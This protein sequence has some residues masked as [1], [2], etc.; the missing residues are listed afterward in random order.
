MKKLYF[1]IACLLGS[2]SECYE[3]THTEKKIGP[4]K[5]RIELKFNFKPGEYLYKE[6]I[7][8]SVNNPHVKLST[9]E[10]SK[11]ATSFFDEASKKQ[12]EGYKDAVTFTLTTEKEPGAVVNEALV[13]MHFSVNT[14]QEPQEKFVAVQFDKRAEKV[15]IGTNVDPALQ[16]K[17]AVA[18]H[19]PGCEVQEP[20]FLGSFIKK[21][22]NW[23]QTSVSRSKATLTTLFTSTGSWA[24]RF[25]AALILGILLSLTPCI[26]PMIP[27]T[28]GI[29]QA[30]GSPSTFKNFLL[31]L[32]YTLGIS[33]TFALLGFFAAVGSCVFGEMQGSP[34]IIIPLALLL[35]YFGLTMFDWVH[36]YIPRFLMPKTGKV[37]GGSPLSAFIFGAISGTIASPCLS[38][39]LVLILNYV[40]NISAQHFS[41]YLEGF[42][43]LFIF[44]IGSS[45]PLLIIGTFSSSLHVLPK[46]GMWMVEIKKIVGLMLIS[47]AFYHLSHLERLLPWYIFVWVIVVSF[48]AL[49]IYYF[50]SIHAHDRTIMKHYK[51]FMGTALIIVACIM[52]LQGQK[53]L[54]DHLHPH[55]IVSAWF[56]DYDQAKEKALKEGK[57]L[58]IDI[59]ATYCAACASL[60]QRIFAV[61]KIQEVLSAF[62]QLKVESDVH[63]TSYERL[64]SIYGKYIEGYPTYLVVDPK[65]DTVLKKWSVEI[66]D[67]SMAGIVDELEKIKSSH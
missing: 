32:S 67:L 63:T 58:F 62:V 49:G 16:G 41:G 33:M 35:I 39:G 54:Y 2:L 50:V 37:K 31:A 61:E 43:L 24:I 34:W 20:S 65:T 30:S 27:I 48:F 21:T 64:K 29:L 6:S 10:P 56:N 18:A 45:L 13:H 17:H 51:N 25:L 66:E 22:V 28:V 12:K 38:P 52:M 1:A 53:A 60:D 7:I 46:A 36:L 8:T 11:G 4:N 57:L 23:V 42:L 19:V 9:L 40:T 15:G 44:G 55:A 59:G 26:Y 5:A 14:T 47:M 3:L